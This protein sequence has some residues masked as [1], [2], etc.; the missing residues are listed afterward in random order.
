MVVPAALKIVRLKPT[1]KV[2]FRFILIYNNLS[3]T[4]M[5]SPETD[6]RIDETTFRIRLL[7]QV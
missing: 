2:R 7:S 6:H 4:M 3:L 5:S 1:R